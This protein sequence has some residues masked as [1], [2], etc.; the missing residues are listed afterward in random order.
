MKERI[1][2]LNCSQL[3]NGYWVNVNYSIPRLMELIKAL[4][5]RCGYSEE[6]VILYGVP[7]G[8]TVEK[9][10]KEPQQSSSGN[11]VPIELAASS[12]HWYCRGDG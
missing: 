10:E 5:L 11:G 7:R 9:K 6:Q 1:E 2:G 8:T 12:F 3:S 4:C